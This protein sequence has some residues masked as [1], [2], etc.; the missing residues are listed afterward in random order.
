[1]RCECKPTPHSVDKGVMLIIEMVL[2]SRNLNNFLP[3]QVG[4]VRPYPQHPSIH[5]RFSVD[6]ASLAA[7]DST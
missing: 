5:A 3:P 2:L 6:S 4:F 7:Y 1:M